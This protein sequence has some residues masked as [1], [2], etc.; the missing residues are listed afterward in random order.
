MSIVVSGDP[1]A[2]AS[3]S[4]PDE[5]KLKTKARQMDGTCRNIEKTP[6][7]RFPA[8]GDTEAPA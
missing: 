7:T 6:R 1:R 4:T 5:P 2:F 8:H 3:H